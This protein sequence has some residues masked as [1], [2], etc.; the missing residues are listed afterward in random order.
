MLL[1]CRLIGAE[2]YKYL[3]A[4]PDCKP[5]AGCLERYIFYYFVCEF[6]IYFILLPFLLA[7]FLCV[8]FFVCMYV[9]Y[10]FIYLC[11]YAFIYLFIYIY[12]HYYYVLRIMQFIYQ[13][14]KA[15]IGVYL[16]RPT[17]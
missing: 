11:M 13:L 12:N 17:R 16:S 8:C 14:F 10:A 6:I 9:I 7:F 5:V 15:K 1:N 2:V 4:C 3:R